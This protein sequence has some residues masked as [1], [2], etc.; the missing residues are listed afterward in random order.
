MKSYDV[1]I[2]ATVRVK[3]WN[4]EAESQ[5]DAVEKARNAVDLYQMF[6]DRTDHGPVEQN[7]PNP[8]IGPYAISGGWAEEISGFL[9]DEVGD[10]NNLNTRYYEDKNIPEVTHAKV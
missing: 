1:H 4:V 10:V 9:V 3:V 2:Y 8:E 6:P 7:R 5:L